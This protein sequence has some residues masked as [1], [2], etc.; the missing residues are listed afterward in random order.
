VCMVRWELLVHF[1]NVCVCVCVSV[2][3]CECVRVALS[4]CACVCQCVCVCSN[5]KRLSSQLIPRGKLWL[6][7]LLVAVL[8]GLACS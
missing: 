3:V 7:L 6:L 2:C 4:V 1:D 5:Y 8:E